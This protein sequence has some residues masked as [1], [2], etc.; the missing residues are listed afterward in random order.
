MFISFPCLPRLWL[1]V[2][3][4]L[5]PTQI[6]VSFAMGAILL[7]PSPGQGTW[8]LEWIW[9]LGW[10]LVIISWLFSIRFC[11]WCLTA[12]TLGVTFLS[13]PLFIYFGCVR[14]YLW[15]MG[16]R[17][18]LHCGMWS[19]QLWCKVSKVWRLSSCSM[20]D[21][22]SLSRD[23][24]HVPCIARQ[25]LNHWITREVLGTMFLI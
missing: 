5:W 25:I 13:L 21:L 3:L 17:G 24:T 8:S 1:V 16:S 18:T 20:W 22:S 6:L 11:P 9:D 19:L 10:A 15:H 7:W 2:Y 23:W 14:S 4:L 12:L